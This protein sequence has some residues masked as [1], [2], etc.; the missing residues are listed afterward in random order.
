MDNEENQVVSARQI[1]IKGL[2][3]KDEKA[4][5]EKKIPEKPGNKWLLV[6]IL[7]VTIIASLVFK[8]S[9]GNVKK[10][11]VKQELQQGSSLFGP[12]VYRYSID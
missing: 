3:K 4:T 10:A 7:V 6:V 9:T 11:P 8:L 12:D 2:D 1:K 5:K